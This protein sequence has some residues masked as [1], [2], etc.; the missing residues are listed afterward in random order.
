MDSAHWR[1]SNPLAHRLLEKRMD[2]ELL[3]KCRDLES[4]TGNHGQEAVQPMAGRQRGVS[5]YGS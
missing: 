3:N 5:P 4:P 2:I 1:I